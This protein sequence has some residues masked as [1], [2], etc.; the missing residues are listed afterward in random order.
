[1]AKRVFSR[2]KSPSKRSSEF[3]SV[4]DG[5][6]FESRP[7]VV[8]SKVGEEG[9]QKDLKT[10]LMQAEHYGHHL[11]Q[12]QLAAVSY[13]GV[14]QRMNDG[15]E[16][17][18]EMPKPTTSKNIAEEMFDVDKFTRPKSFHE[19][20]LDKL[21]ART[22]KKEMNPGLNG[23]P[24]TFYKCGSTG[25]FYQIDAM[26]I[27]HKQPWKEYI[28]SK[29]PKNRKEA[30]NYYNDLNNLQLESSTANRSHDFERDNE[31]NF[32]DKPENY[33]EGENLDEYDYEDIDDQYINEESNIK[34]N[35][36]LDN[37]REKDQKRKARPLYKNHNK[38]RRIAP[39]EVGDFNK[40]EKMAENIKNNL[41]PQEIQMLIKKLQ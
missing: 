13:R 8:Q 41:T 21:A 32:M 9:K 11:N 3:S 10:S 24:E 17:Q 16:D 6:M 34:S 19:N 27:G 37:Q 33:Q 28:K 39:E 20:I 4:S 22:E 7:F 31:G 38:I 35:E 18:G 15:T 30:I 29:K 12:M 2:V 23:H 5:G 26:D 40:V 25:R 14:V 1:M 36:N